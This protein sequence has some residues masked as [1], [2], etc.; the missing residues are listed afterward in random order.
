MFCSLLRSMCPSN[1]NARP[2]S[3]IASPS[4]I[5]ALTLACYKLSLGHQEPTPP[6]SPL[7]TT[8]PHER[9]ASPSTTSLSSMSSI[10]PPS[11]PSSPTLSVDSL[12]SASPDAPVARKVKV[13]IID[14]NPVNLNILSRMLERH[15]S[16]LVE[17]TLVMDSG[18]TALDRLCEDAVDLI[19]MDIDMP[20]LSGVQTT[21][22]IRQNSDQH[23]LEQN[24]NV[25]IIAVTTSDGEDQRELYRSVGMS[26]CVSKP[27]EV[28]KLRSAIEGALKAIPHFAA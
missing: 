3:T 8:A 27:I 14:D 6:S 11:S 2:T 13:M 26:D 21:T 18:V 28:P 19:L 16:D 1:S 10:T 15:F 22:A 23:I 12:M 7:I 5:A 24:Q 25:P 17:L 4:S 20:V 9:L